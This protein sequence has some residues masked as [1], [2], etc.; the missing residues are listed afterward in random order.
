MFPQ[1]GEAMVSSKPFIDLGPVQTQ[2]TVEGAASDYEG[3]QLLFL[4]L[5][6]SLT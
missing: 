3:T 6:Q 5:L 4:T 2:M 1:E